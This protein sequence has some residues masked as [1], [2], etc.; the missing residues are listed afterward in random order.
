MLRLQRAESND[1]ARLSQRQSQASLASVGSSD[2]GEVRR[3][4]SASSG[5]AAMPPSGDGVWTAAPPV[6]ESDGARADEEWEGPPPAT[7]FPEDECGTPKRSDFAAAVGGL[8]Q[9]LGNRPF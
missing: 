7:P 6:A 2:G 9:S 1:E 4:G 3:Q 8:A 5:A